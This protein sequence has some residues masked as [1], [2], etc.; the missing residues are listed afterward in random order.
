MPFSRSATRINQR[1]REGCD[2]G[3]RPICLHCNQRQ[4]IVMKRAYAVGEANISGRRGY[5]PKEGK[6]QDA[7]QV[8]QR[9]HLDHPTQRV[10]EFAAL[11]KL[12]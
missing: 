8:L 2:A 7:L 9:F 10:F 5:K 6:R 11:V 3:W 4:L 1:T 12:D